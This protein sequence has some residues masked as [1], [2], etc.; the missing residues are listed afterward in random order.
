[1][2]R[3]RKKYATPVV[4]DLGDAATLTAGTASGGSEE[5]AVCQ[6]ANTYWKNST[7]QHKPL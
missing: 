2:I 6:S 3:M 7:N 5:Q 1:M 4:F